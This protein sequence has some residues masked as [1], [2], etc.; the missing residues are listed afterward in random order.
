MSLH[1]RRASSQEFSIH[2]L[3][4]QQLLHPPLL[5]LHPIS[6][7]L[8]QSAS[9]TLASVSIPRNKNGSYPTIVMIALAPEVGLPWKVPSRDTPYMHHACM[10]VYILICIKCICDAYTMIF[11]RLLE[12]LNHKPVVRPGLSPCSASS[13][14]P[15]NRVHWR[16][17]TPG[18]RSYG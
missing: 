2:A 7:Y 1:V 12:L 9:S 17:R 18:Q 15:K 6:R 8:I 3:K 5:R 10:Y 14:S 4:F 13:R 16:C 11:G